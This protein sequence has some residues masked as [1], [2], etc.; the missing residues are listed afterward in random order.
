MQT[1]RTMSDPDV[2]AAYIL[3]EQM[4]KLNDGKRTILSLNKRYPGS[5]KNRNTELKNLEE[6][7]RKC[8]EQLK[9]L[10]NCKS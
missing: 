7:I 10:W 3:F 5:T 8:A 2:K 4:D 9:P 1:Y 6:S